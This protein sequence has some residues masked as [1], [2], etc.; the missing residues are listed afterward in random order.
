M[1]KYL[2]VLLLSF[3][4]FCIPGIDNPLEN[5]DSSKGS[6]AFAMLA[7]FLGGAVAQATDRPT[8]SLP[9]GMG[10][11]SIVRSDMT[12]PEHFGGAFRAI[13]DVYE[14]GDPNNPVKF[15]NG[16]AEIEYK[17]DKDRILSSGLML[18]FQVFWY[19]RASQEWK[20]V[21]KLRY[22]ESREVLIAY[23]SHLTPFVPAATIA[24]SGDTTAPPAC[25]AEDYPTNIGGSNASSAGFMV[26]GEGF[27]YY[28]DRTYTIVPTSVSSINQ[29]SF[30]AYG[31]S[32]AVG[33]ATCNGNGVGTAGCG[34]NAQEKAYSGND[35]I[36]FTAQ[37]NIDLYLMYDTRGGVNLNDASKDASWIQSSGFVS[38]GNFVET[39]DPMRFYRI[40]KKAFSVGQ[41]VRL[42]GN[43][44]GVGS[45]A[46]DTNYWLIMKPQGNT[47]PAPSTSLCV[48]AAPATPGS[49]SILI[50]QGGTNI[51]HGGNYNF[52][53]VTP[54]GSTGP[55]GFSIHNFGDSNLELPG[56]PVVSI[57]G[58]DAAY[59]NVVQP[60]FPIASGQSA[61]FSVS[62]NPITAGFKTAT[63]VVESN[64]PSK[65]TY[66][67]G[68]QGHAGSSNK[69]ITSFTI[70]SPTT[71]G[72][73]VGHD[74]SLSVPF[75]TNVTNLVTSFTF[76]GVQVRVGGITQ[77]SG[78]TINN[79]TNPIVYSVQAQ[80]GT[81]QNYTVSVTVLPEP[82]PETPHISQVLASG[83]KAFVEWY[84]SV[85][86]TTY[87]VYYGSSPGITTGSAFNPPTSQHFAEITGLTPGILYYFRVVATNS[88]GN[89][90][91]SPESSAITT[92]IPFG[93]ASAGAHVDI[94]AGQGN[95]SAGQRLSPLFDLVN[96]KILVVAE[97]QANGSRPGLFHCNMDGSNCL[98]KDISADQ[99]IGS[100][101]EPS[102]VIDPFNHKILVVANNQSNGNL[103]GLFRCDLDGNNCTYKNISEG[104]GLASAW[105]SRLLLDLFNK[106]LLLVTV[107]H[108][109]N[110]FVLLRCDLEGNSCTNSRIS[111]G[112][113]GG[114]LAAVIDYSNKKLLVAT[115]NYL[116]E[117]KP[118]LFRCNL[119]GS[120]CSHTDISSGQGFESGAYPT[121]V[122]DIL[123]GKILVVTTN[124]DNGA[125]LGLFRC[126][127]DGSACTHTD[128]S[129]NQG[130]SNGNMKSTF[131]D[132]V[133]GKLLVVIEQYTNEFKPSLFRCNVDG[134]NCNQTDISS[135]Q[136][137]NSGRFPSVLID[138]VSGKLLVVTT[139]YSNNGKPSIFLW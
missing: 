88:G 30:A 34:Q 11:P 106:K 130:D 81:T 95:G 90:A 6:S 15:Q 16:F 45:P 14:I 85:G 112:L 92:S 27:Q 42:H 33:V 25:I 3:F 5:N 110:D 32:N 53:N 72:T 123:N 97:N 124:I 102:A 114:W 119:D 117:D 73:I 76:T 7:L 129:A 65:P 86:A 70:N 109:N 37:S 134:T 100:G 41:E 29:T 120:A 118:S 93:T 43:K 19:D 58:A 68:L 82:T 13:G 20:P 89:S 9:N 111:A 61:N 56:T 125:R 74:I 121:I 79:F 98:Y 133:N 77:T 35:Y 52:G 99:G 84:P 24:S 21:D 38:T 108:S 50:R 71:I 2:I 63:M 137:F 80:D 62:F 36:V 44:N 94:S 101:I 103:P 22:D 64:D 17:I 66:S 138:P 1:K 107:D 28:K 48:T 139:N 75:G 49:A 59:F 26:V 8:V 40:Y 135:G 4:Q 69:S 105:W 39:T 46:I 104:Q 132:S 116:N 78:V 96:H 113:S 91:L 127:L 115:T 12:P 31:F 10:S 122:L 57:T 126:N 131:L 18:E 60:T 47:T 54:G 128:I 51:D 67:V 87:T 136:G 83:T 55:I 23:T